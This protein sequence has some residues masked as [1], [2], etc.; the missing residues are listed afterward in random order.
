MPH[1]EP[2]YSRP[3]ILRRS[4]VEAEIGEGRSQLYAHM[5]SGLFPRPVKLTGS[6]SVGWPADEVRAVN[7]AR[8]AGVSESEMRS[9]VARLMDGRKARA[10]A[11]LGGEA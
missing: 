5:A 1:H 11:A 2:P 10:S 3:A 7:A 4:A 9:L 8:I 6:R